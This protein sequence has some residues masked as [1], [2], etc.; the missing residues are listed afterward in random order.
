MAKK[1][2]SKLSK[3]GLDG[4]HRD[5]SGQI[6]KKHGRTK[7]GSLR[8]TYGAHFAKG[9]RSD[10]MLETL[11]KKTGTPSLHQYLKQHHS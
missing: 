6:D 1:R 9:H 2:K 8:K 5:K 7:I 4:R 10:M 3:V 11:L